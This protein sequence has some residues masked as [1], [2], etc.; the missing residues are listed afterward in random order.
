MTSYQDRI[1]FGGTASVFNIVSF[2]D[3]K[4]EDYGTED[5]KD[6]NVYDFDKLYSAYMKNKEFVSDIS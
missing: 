1:A 5:E 6:T 2:H 3:P 4:H